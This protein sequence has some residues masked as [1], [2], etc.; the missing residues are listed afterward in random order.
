VQ[1]FKS[2]KSKLRGQYWEKPIKYFG[3]HDELDQVIP[4]AFHYHPPTSVRSYG[5][6]GFWGWMGIPDTPIRAQQGLRF[7]AITQSKR[8]N[9]PN[10]RGGE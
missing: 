10:R 9:D 3:T 8:S 4:F 7:L 6:P 2:E 1:I 5:S